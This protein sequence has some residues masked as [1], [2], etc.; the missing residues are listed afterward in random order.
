MCKYFICGLVSGY[1]I[2]RGLSFSFLQSGALCGILM[3]FLMA[4]FLLLLWL[5]LECLSNKSK[6]RCSRGISLMLGGLWGHPQEL[7]G[8]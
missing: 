6:V 4:I 3:K 2:H 1:A 8:N 7:F 5:N